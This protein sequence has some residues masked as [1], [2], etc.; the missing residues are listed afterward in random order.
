MGDLRSPSTYTI[1]Q[2][3]G[4]LIITMKDNK[5]IEIIFLKNKSRTMMTIFVFWKPITK[6]G[7]FQPRKPGSFTCAGADAGAKTLV[8]SGHVNPQI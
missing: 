6:H 7:H 2:A 3:R 8:A 5:T 1:L 4:W